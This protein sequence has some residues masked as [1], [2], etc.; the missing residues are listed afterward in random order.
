LQT[1]LTFFTFLRKLKHYYKLKSAV[2]LFS[3]V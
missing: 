3:S 2:S 1:F